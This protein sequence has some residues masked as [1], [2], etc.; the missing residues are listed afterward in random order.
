MQPEFRPSA[1]PHDCPSTCALEVEV[2]DDHTIGRVRGNPRNDYTAGVICAKVAA[3]RERVHHPDRLTHPLQRVGAKGSGE[4]RRISWGQALDEVAEAIERARAVHG[5]ETVWPYHFAG[6]M[7]LVQRDSIH[8]FRHAFGFSREHETICVTT[9]CNGWVAGHGKIWGAD[10]RE[11]AD[12]DLIVVWGGNP[13]STQVNVMTHIAKARK[14]RGAK[15]VVID[16]YRTPTAE[17][18]DLHI[19]LRPGTDGALAC[20]IMQVLFEEGMADW[21]YMREF[22]D[23]PNRLHQHLSTRTPEWAE[24]ITGIPADDI[25]DLARLYGQ[26]ERAYLR[27]GYGFTRSRNGAA[28]MHAVTC[29]PVVTGKWKYRGGGALFSNRELYGVDQTLIRGLDVVDPSTRALDMSQIGRV[30]TGDA[31]ALKGGPPVTVLFTQNINPAEVAPETTRVIDG[32]MRDDLFTCVHEQF[33]TASAKL[34]DIVLPATMFLEHEDMYQGGGHFYLQVHKALIEPLGECRSNVEVINGLAQRLGSDYPAF[35]M[36]AWELI[37]DALRRSGRPGA[38]AVLAEGWIDCTKPFEDAHFLNGF[39]HG[40]GKFHFAADW[41]AIGEDCDGMSALPDHLNVIDDATDAHPYR[42]VAAPARRFLN[43]TFTETPSSRKKEG[44]PTALIH[45]ETCTALGL[46]EGDRVRLGNELG[47]LV[48]HVR[49]F[50]GLQTHT[51]VVEGIWPNEAFEEGRG[52]NTIISADAA[53][54]GGGAAFHDTAIW[55]RPA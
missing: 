37:D 16:P 11:I 23:D 30:L 8:R 15:L 19:P 45:P 18:A 32:M 46:A 38:D 44:R 55:M 27:C 5:A 13:V 31:K 7:G 54:P 34:A 36:T 20:A 52:I 47:D 9:A 1:C 25:R 6:T 42:L 35:H 49:P 12:S 29:L 50:D 17:V 40:D 53:L 3:Y 39:G 22:S 21:D 2:L 51:V 4:F 26:T 41:S 14:T 33:M 24:A 43:T 48:V 28:N 10:P